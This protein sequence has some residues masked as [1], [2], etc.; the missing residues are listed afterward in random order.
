M[1]KY[2]LIVGAIIV[3]LSL[4]WAFTYYKYNQAMLTS[5]KKE[6]QLNE[7]EQSVDIFAQLDS[8][9]PEHFEN[10]VAAKDEVLV[11]I[12]RPDCIDCNLF[13]LLLL[14][15][16]NQNK[17]IKNKLVYLNVAALRKSDKE[18]ARFKEKY[19]VKYT[20]TIAL[21]IDGKQKRKAQWTPD[22]PLTIQEVKTIVE[23]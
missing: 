10:K 23:N 18:W 8:I 15:Y 11:Y 14:N 17:E 9:T 20:P 4:C 2:K 16:L 21:Y 3:F 5:Q 1:K 13:D 22:K 6:E 7:L 19:E 12:G